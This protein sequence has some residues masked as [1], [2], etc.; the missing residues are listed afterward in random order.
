MDALFEKQHLDAAIKDWGEVFTPESLVEEMLGKIPADI[1]LNDEKTVLDHSCGNGNF[2]VKV[3]ELR[4]KNGSSHESALST[5]YGIEI[6]EANAIACRERLSL[7]S[8]SKEIWKILNNN[9]V[10][11]DA[12]DKNHPGWIP[13]GYMWSGPA[14]YTKFFDL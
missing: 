8:R 14:A 7:K 1:L 5:I 4:L 9:I 6:D 12:L 10:C 13:V 2:L 11:A 3:L